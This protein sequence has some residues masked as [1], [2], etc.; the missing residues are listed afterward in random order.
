[1]IGDGGRKTSSLSNHDAG[2]RMVTRHPLLSSP[3]ST[4]AQANRFF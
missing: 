2:E 4:W 1:L 3:T